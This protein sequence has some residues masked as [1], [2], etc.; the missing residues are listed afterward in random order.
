VASVLP[1][2]QID[3]EVAG[4]GGQAERVVEFPKREQAGIGGD[5]RTVEFQLQ[6][7]V[8]G[9]PQ[10]GSPVSPVA[11]SIRRLSMT[12]TPLPFIV[13]SRTGVIARPG[14]LGHPGS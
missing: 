1:G 14:Y 13:D 6:S 7:A 10:P 2:A 9:D 8:E 5:G 4:Q 12:A 3:E 11:S